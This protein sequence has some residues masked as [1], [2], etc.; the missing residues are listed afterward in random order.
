MLE[1]DVTVTAQVSIIEIQYKIFELEEI[2]V[3]DRVVLKRTYTKTNKLDKY[4]SLDK[5]CVP[6]DN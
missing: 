4:M 2:N 5:I 1:L 3:K 6:I